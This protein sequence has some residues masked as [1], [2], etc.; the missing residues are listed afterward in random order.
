MVPLSVTGGR[1]SE[2]GP[3][4]REYAGNIRVFIYLNLKSRPC[5]P[6]S[7]PCFPIASNSSPYLS[8]V[9]LLIISPSLFARKFK[10]RI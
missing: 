10:V 8:F 5:S 9:F 3:I 7:P 1:N 2:C 4:S 6:F